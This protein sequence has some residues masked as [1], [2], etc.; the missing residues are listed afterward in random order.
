MSCKRVGGRLDSSRSIGQK[1]CRNN[2]HLHSRMTS[3]FAPSPVTRLEQRAGKIPA[4][5]ENSIYAHGTILLLSYL[6]SK[7]AHVKWADEA[8]EYGLF[9]SPRAITR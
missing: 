2:I 7:R 4:L 9:D 8:S 1:D 6:I 5:F 3:Q